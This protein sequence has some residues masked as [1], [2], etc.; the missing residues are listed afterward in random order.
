MSDTIKVYESGKTRIR[1]ERDE[2]PI[3]PWIL[4][5]MASS[6]AAWNEDCSYLPYTGNEKAQKKLNEQY[7]FIE[8]H[9]DM[10]AWIDDAKNAHRP[11]LVFGWTHFDK[12]GGVVLHTNNNKGVDQNDLEQFDGALFIDEERFREYVDSKTQ[13]SD[14]TMEARMVDVLQAEFDQ[15]N[16]YASGC[17]FGFVLEKKCPT[18]G[19]WEIKD[20]VWGYECL[21][22]EGSK[23]WREMCMAMLENID[24]DI[25]GI[26]KQMLGE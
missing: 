25:V 7:Q 6:L 26:T 9:D 14:A 1:I 8:S 16:A 24:S 15:L 2:N 11:Y 20:S 5:D 12:Y 13:M 19:Q 4:N 22:P 3:H 21:Q 18:C 10:Q 23:E 17:C